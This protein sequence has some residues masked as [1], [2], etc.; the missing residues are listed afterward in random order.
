[1]HGEDLRILLG[2][3]ERALGGGELRT[4]QHGQQATDS[5]EDQ[6]REHEALAHYIVVDRRELRPSG[7][8]P[9]D[10][11]ESLVEGN[12]RKVGLSVLRHFVSCRMMAAA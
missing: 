11:I 2:I 1:M 9:P 4:D 6:C 10:P 3:H 5:E 12:G 7:R 8:R